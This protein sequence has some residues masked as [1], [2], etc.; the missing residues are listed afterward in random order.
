MVYKQRDWRERIYIA[1]AADERSD[2]PDHADHSALRGAAAAASQPQKKIISTLPGG[3]TAVQHS[4]RHIS[5]RRRFSVCSARG[6][7]RLSRVE[8]MMSMQIFGRRSRPNTKS[9]RVFKATAK[10]LGVRVL[11][12]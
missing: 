10:R 4:M 1:A 7:M 2:S 3:S 5:C 6:I 11:D 9:S 12:E 8:R